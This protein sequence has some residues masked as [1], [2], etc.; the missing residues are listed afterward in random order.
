MVNMI[1][2]ELSED[3]QRQSTRN[4]MVLTDHQRPIKRMAIYACGHLVKHEPAKR[5]VLHVDAGDRNYLL[6]AHMGQ[7]LVG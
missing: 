2:H 7:R 5:G 6:P 4:C 3:S 1:A